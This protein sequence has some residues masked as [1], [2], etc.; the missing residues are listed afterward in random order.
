M[1]NG[2]AG[3]P[4]FLD[5]NYR[6]LLLIIT[7]ITAASCVLLVYARSPLHGLNCADSSVPPRGT[8]DHL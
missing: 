5:V 7:T 6:I 4:A 2:N 1:A 8:L 3:R